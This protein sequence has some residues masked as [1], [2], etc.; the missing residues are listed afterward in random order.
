[1]NVATQTWF[2]MIAARFVPSGGFVN[3]WVVEHRGLLCD[4]LTIMIVCWMQH[5]VLTLY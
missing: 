3:D 1:M 2:S 5:S 4:V